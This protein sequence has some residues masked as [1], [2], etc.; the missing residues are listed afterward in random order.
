[1]GL[2][3]SKETT[4]FLNIKSE[5]NPKNYKLYIY[6]NIG[7]SN[8]KDIMNIRFGHVGFGI[9]EKFIYG[10][11]PNSGH[12]MSIFNGMY[13]GNIKNDKMLFNEIVSINKKKTGTNIEIKK[14]IVNINEKAYNE[15]NNWNNNIINYKNIKNIKYGIKYNKEINLGIKKDDDIKFANCLT[16]LDFFSPEYNGELLN[17]YDGI[18]SKFN[19]EYSK[20]KLKNHYFTIN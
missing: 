9:S 15:I 5:N 6:W 12:N 17:T 16:F 10:F 20:Y 11:H 4:N 7:T 14:I 18:M 13:Y 19:N 2:F 1:M 8:P 3:N